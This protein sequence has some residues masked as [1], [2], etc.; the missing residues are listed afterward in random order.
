MGFTAAEQGM[1]F[2]SKSGVALLGASRQGWW[3]WVLPSLGKQAELLEPGWNWPW[4]HD[5]VV[6]FIKVL[7]RTFPAPQ[8]K[9]LCLKAGKHPQ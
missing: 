8:R 4:I 5:R 2:A 7:L 3:N 6:T 9:P 1:T